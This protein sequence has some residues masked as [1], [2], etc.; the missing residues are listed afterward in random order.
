MYIFWPHGPIWVSTKSTEVALRFCDHDIETVLYVFMISTQL[1]P[2]NFVYL[3][4]HGNFCYLRLWGVFSGHCDGRVGKWHQS[5]PLKTTPPRASP[6]RP[7]G[8]EKG[9]NKTNAFFV[10]IGTIWQMNSK[11]WELG[12]PKHGQIH[13]F[14]CHSRKSSPT[15]P[16]RN[17]WPVKIASPK[18]HLPGKDRWRLPPLP[19]VLVYHHPLLFAGNRHP[20]WSGDSHLGV[21]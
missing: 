20:F 5:S 18:T 17:S 16:F 7:V 11:T 12:P 6:K 9:G 15:H 2:Q 13:I 1:E 21:K 4:N 3:K 10:N 8:L 14:P 19:F